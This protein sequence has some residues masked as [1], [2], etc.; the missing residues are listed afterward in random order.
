MKIVKKY[1]EY[2]QNKNFVKRFNSLS[3]YKI[4]TY[5]YYEIHNFNEHIV[6]FDSNRSL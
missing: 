3:I 2:Q 5:L 4:S 6:Q 1:T